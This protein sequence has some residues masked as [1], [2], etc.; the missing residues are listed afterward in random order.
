M[1]CI[2]SGLYEG[3]MYLVS[4]WYVAGCDVVPE[5]RYKSNVP[6][7]RDALWFRSA[8]SR[9]TEDLT[10][11][12][13]VQEPIDRLAREVGRPPA[14]P[15]LA[16]SC[17]PLAVWACCNCAMRPNPRRGVGHRATH[18]GSCSFRKTVIYA[19]VY[20]TPPGVAA[21]PSMCTDSM[22]AT[23]RCVTFLGER[24]RGSRR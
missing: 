8:I 19:S 12:R 18:D 3:L 23:P 2:M 4:S 6:A 14:F 16:G 15:V 11:I 17:A 13:E 7:V 5:G 20:H 9:S 10:A 22:R 1:W 21:C 24:A